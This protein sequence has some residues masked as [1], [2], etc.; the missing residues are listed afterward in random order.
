MIR[1]VTKNDFKMIFFYTGK[2]ILGVGLTMFI[3]LVTS[4]IYQEWSTTIDFLIAISLCLVFF[5]ITD[6]YLN[7]NRSP[8]LFQSMFIAAFSWLVAC[9]LGAVPHYLSGH[10]GSYL[11]AYF[12]LMSGYTTSGLTL[13]KDLDHIS[14]GLSMWRQLLTY[15]GGQGIVVLALAF[16]IKSTGGAYKIMVGEGKDEVLVPSVRRTSQN[17][18]IVSIATLIVGTFILAI[19]AWLDGFRFDAGILH[20]MWLFMSS[21]STGGFAP[22]AQNIQFY[23]SYAFEYVNVVFM[24]MGGFNFALHYA[25]WKGNFNELRKNIEIIT[26]SLTF[27]ITSIFVAWGLSK[28]G[29][30]ENVN[31]IIRRGIINVVSAHT[32]A[33]LQTLYPRQ[34]F[35]LDP[36]AFFGLCLAMAL[37]G[38]AASTAGGFKSIRTGLVFK[39]IGLEIKRLLLPESAVVSS[40]FHHIKTQILSTDLVRQAALIITGYIIIYALGTIVGVACGYSLRMSTFE[41]ISAASN[42]GISSGLTSSTMPWIIKV[43]YIFTMWIGRL[44][45]MAVYVFF[46]TLFLTVA[47]IFKRSKNVT[48]PL[49]TNIKDHYYGA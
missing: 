9:A 24:I 5:L 2:V 38:C 40:K 11:D 17:I 34:I 16:L 12:D 30:F 4:L 45:F 8:N 13:I 27:S 25:V 20:G 18:W 46:G 33:G 32:T 31:S 26:F 21:W 22:N 10:F 37:G 49:K 42:S 43:T 39:G 44:E 47:G 23:H 28:M 1:V 15:I 41:S 48:P 6:K 14:I 36:L 3:P 7:T 19:I 35:E 29:I